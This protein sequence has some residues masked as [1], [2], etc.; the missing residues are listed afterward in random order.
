MKIRL[1][2]P[3]EIVKVQEIKETL[4]ELT[5]ERYVDNPGLKVVR[6]FIKEVHEPIILWEGVAYDNIGQWTDEDANKR[7][8][9]LYS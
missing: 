5:I 1:E 7:L 2:K 3:K 4:T 6:V 8:Q 9:E